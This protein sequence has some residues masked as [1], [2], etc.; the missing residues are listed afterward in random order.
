MFLSGW[1]S[2]YQITAI[3]YQLSHKHIQKGRNLEMWEWCWK[4]NGD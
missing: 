1:I 2:N 3:L 4:W